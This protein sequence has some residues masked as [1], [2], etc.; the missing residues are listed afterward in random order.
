[1]MNVLNTKIV[2]NTK[3][4]TNKGKV[5]PMKHAVYKSV[6][7]TKG[8]CGRLKGGHW[9]HDVIAGYLTDIVKC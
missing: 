5:C 2:F 8:C 9:Q 4:I 7:E 6:L 3:Q 1:M